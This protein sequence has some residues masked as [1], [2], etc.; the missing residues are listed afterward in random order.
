MRRT[1]VMKKSQMVYGPW[2]GP[3]LI[4]AGTSRV[5]GTLPVG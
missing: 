3:G 4:Y 1:F 2:Y 5:D